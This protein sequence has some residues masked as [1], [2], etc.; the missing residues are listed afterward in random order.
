MDFFK[1]QFEK[2][3]KELQEKRHIQGQMG[4]KRGVSFILALGFLIG[5]YSYGLPF[6]GGLTLIFFLLFIYYLINDSQIKNEI[7]VLESRLSVLKQYLDRPNGLW[8]DFPKDGKKYL[9]D[10]IPQGK[11]LDLFGSRSLYQL[12]CAANTVYGRDNLATLLLSFLHP[13]VCI[14]DRQEAVEELADKK[15]LCTRLQT[16]SNLIGGSK[17]ESRLSSFVN[18]TKEPGDS[19]NKIKSIIKWVLPALTVLALIATGIS[20][21]NSNMSMIAFGLFILQLV[22]SGIGYSKNSLIFGTYSTFSDDMKLY[23][24]IFE[25]IE[26]ETFK[27]PMLTEIQ[28][29]FTDKNGASKAMKK[30]YAIGERSKI[31]YNMIGYLIFNGLFLWDSHCLSQ[32][33]NWKKLYGGRCEEWLK[34]FGRLEGLMSLSVLADVYKEHVFPTIVKGEN[35]VLSAT[36]VRHP[37]LPAKTSVG[38]PVNTYAG[39]SII[40][41]SNMSGKTTYLRSIGIN[42]VLAYAGAP[43]LAKTFR[44]SYMKMFTSIR[45]EDDVSKGISTFYAEILRIKNTIA[46]LDEKKPM[47]VLIDEIFTGTNSADRIMAA[48]EVIKSL[49]TKR[50]IVMVTT[51]DFELCKLE[52]EESNTVNYHFSEYYKD[53]KIMFDYLMKSGQCKTTNARQ[54]LRLAGILKN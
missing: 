51:H 32:F 44:V 27:S 2:T 22:I 12:L 26:K 31:R 5:G 47:L 10:D 38:N 19:P 9:S 6:M 1:E 40:T 29:S 18:E 35:P 8:Y 11:D 42:I 50:N 45:I 15:E 46:Y 30:L 20:K 37:F 3:S 52:S 43:V 21:G 7:K 48:Q 36:D 25:E 49:T 34:E 16:F 54:L 28:Q 33:Y 23:Q 53:D 24:K 41:G 39:T 17:Q 14:E 13:P 4:K